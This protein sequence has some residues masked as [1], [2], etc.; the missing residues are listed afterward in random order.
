MRIKFIDILRLISSALITMLFISNSNSQIILSEIMFDPA[1]SEYYNEF[2][3]IY[4][5]SPTDTI[6]LSGWQ[7]SDS[8]D[9][10]FIIFYE[11]GSKLKPQQYA[12]I[13]DPGYFENSS[14]YE[15]LIPP[16]TL[17]LTIDDGAFGSQGLSNSTAE[18]IILIASDGD[19]VAKYRYSLD[20]QP[21]YSD[22][23][24]NF[25]GDDSPENWSN[26]KLLNGTPGFE[27]SVRQFDYDIKLDL[28]GF[29]TEAN[30]GQPITLI[31]SATNI[32]IK[33]AS[34]IQITFFEDINSDSLLTVDEQIG[35]SHLIP[36]SLK[37]NETHQIHIAIDLLPSG[38][39]FFYAKAYF[40]LDQ[41][42]SNNFALSLVKIGYRTKQIIIN[43]IM[44]RPPGGVAEWLELYNPTAESIN[45][46]F[47][48][49][50]DANIDKRINISENVLFVP[51][52][53]YLIISEDSTIYQAFPAIPCNVII[54]GQG[55]PALN[56][57]G[58][59]IYLYDPIGIIIDQVNYEVSW[60]SE[61]GISLERKRD[62]L[63]SNNPSNWALSQ[64]VNGGTPGT[65]NSRSPINYDLEVA[66][67]NFISANPFPGEELSIAITVSNVGRFTISEFQLSCSIDL[68]Q[69]SLFQNNERIVDPFTISEIL[70]QDESATILIPFT[71]THS[72]CYSVFA[73]LISEKDT[74][75]SNNFCS[76]VL[77]IGFEKG[78]LI[79]NEIMYSP[80][81]DQPEWI[82]L[83]NPHN[84]SINIQNWSFSDSDSSVLQ[85]T[86]ENHFE[87]APQT[88]LILAP[89]SSILDY[90][91]LN[92]S[93]LLTVKKFPRLNDDK[94][95]IFIFDANENVID[96]VSYLS[97]WGGEN[98]VSL[99]RINPNLA[100]GDSS[101]W[102]SCVLMTNGGTPGRKNS[103]FVEVLPGEAELS[104]SPNPFSPDGDGRDDV[105][106]I[107][108][109][110]PF[111][112][113]QVHVKI[114]D[115]RGR[116]VRF[117][118]NNQPSATINSIIWDGRDD[119]GHTCRIGIY[120]VYLEAIHYQRG[121]VKSLKKSVILAKQL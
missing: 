80:P 62:D 116:Q 56:N 11:M 96:E 45:L 110:L 108:Y 89:D 86:I 40:S 92:N 94:D 1:G 100:S 60:G 71:P 36:D 20:N 52:K 103:I 12:I 61:A 13:L 14:Q 97:N 42:N 29:P 30:P 84:N 8:V 4:N 53:C 75:S 51:E 102:S 93:P 33:N 90:F 6:D 98:G 32:G 82:E 118:V 44:Y 119:R 79:I 58:D 105:T 3:E 5:I 24:Q 18:P 91:D 22:E 35:P 69:D 37:N 55:F 72:G 99:E 23:K 57:N 15:N 48:K 111:N 9:V 74:N 101:N 107:N 109:Q 88:F 115:I 117:L 112:L 31:A 104:I 81:P 7:I 66:E 27:N 67:V 19:T 78:S 47:W 76:T 113:S 65:N 85:S 46:Q 64:N 70:A 2:I 21:G 95:K 68:N 17:I 59:N 41:D 73:A 49:F 16:E 77:S 121:V 39:H 87:I 10:D 114:F 83:Y 106:I 120:I 34:D 50:S 28:L 26:S 63:E 54:P 25:W 38:P 43:E